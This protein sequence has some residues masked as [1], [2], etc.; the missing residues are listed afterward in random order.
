MVLISFGQE[1][2]R[3]AAFA[4]LELIN[5][6]EV[7]ALAVRQLPGPGTRVFE[8]D[9][10]EREANGDAALSQVLHHC[11][12]LNVLRFRAARLS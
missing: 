11:R 7:N 12:P 1:E 9:G 8:W 3:S 4:L 10:D 2:A 5:R 6:L